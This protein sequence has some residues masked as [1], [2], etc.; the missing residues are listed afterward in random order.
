MD[1]SIL[2]S[3]SLGV[4]VGILMGLTGAGGGILSV[5][6][7][8]FALHLPVAQVAPISLCAIALAAGV[9][10]L[11]GFRNKILRYKAAG[12]MAIFG[13]LFSPIGLWLATKFQ[14]AHY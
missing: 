11:L 5:P 4:L 1:F 7:L 6:L 9:G 10:A 2:I 14:I 8:V 3:P 12:L 13:L